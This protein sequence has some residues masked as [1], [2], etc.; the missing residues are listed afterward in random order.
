[1][2]LA[3]RLTVGLLGLCLTAAAHAEVTI[4]TGAPE[5]AGW[6]YNAENQEL[7]WLAQARTLATIEFEKAKIVPGTLVVESDAKEIVMI[8]GTASPTRFDASNQTGHRI[9]FTEAG[10]RPTLKVDGSEW[11]ALRGPWVSLVRDPS[12]ALRLELRVATY[13]TVKFVPVG[14]GAGEVAGEDRPATQPAE[15]AESDDGF[16]RIKVAQDGT[17]DRLTA[18]AK[19]LCDAIERECKPCDGKGSTKVRKKVGTR[20]EGIWEVPEFREVQESCKKC[21]GRG[22]VRAEI[23]VLGRLS[24]GFVRALATVKPDHER[25]QDALRRAYES[26]SANVLGDERAWIALNRRGR[27][28]ITQ[29]SITPGTPVMIQARVW[30]TLSELTGS[31]TDRTMIGEV[32]GTDQM[33]CFLSPQSADEAE[34]GARVL[35]G[36]VVAG[37]TKMGDK[38]VIVIQNGFVISPN[39]DRGWRWWYVD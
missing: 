35:A 5:N 13:A 9:E 27:G 17:P 30:G 8:S 22:R 24:D 12:P 3:Q 14:T 21:E 18:S 33:L 29:R 36:G 26:V 16:P 7:L 10:G 19:S 25:T 32:A 2:R 34:K 31:G 38:S 1:M 39:V 20:K 4:I 15:A 23:E 6:D 11:A 28:I 37:V